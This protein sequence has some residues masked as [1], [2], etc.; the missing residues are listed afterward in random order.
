MSFLSMT[1]CGSGQAAA[2]GWRVEVELAC[3]NRKQLDL[4]ANLPR[5]LADLEPELLIRIRRH[6][7]RGRVSLRVNLTPAGGT[8][9][10]T[11]VIDEAAARQALERLR[12][13]GTALH[14][15]PPS[16]LGE[17]HLLAPFARVEEATPAPDRAS[18]LVLEALD[19][20]LTRFQEMRRREGQAL[21]ADVLARL[22][23]VERTVQGIADRAPAAVTTLRERL[24]QRLRE[25]GLALD[26][27]DERV[28]KELALHADRCDVS[29]E[30]T[31]LASHFQQFRAACEAPEPSGRTLD[32]LCQEIGREINTLGAKT[33]DH[34][35]SSDLIWLKTELERIREQI[36]NVE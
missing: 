21:R 28:L 34:R 36:Q 6:L 5:A 18:S 12:A 29:E 23:G 25:A 9:A 20:A 32:F 15:A 27:A 26:V 11:L 24:L 8:P 33:A 35:A 16:S 14:L 22:A 1:G 19:Q 30:L 4:A 10:R 3:V 31:R 2:E 13:L 7:S 17:L